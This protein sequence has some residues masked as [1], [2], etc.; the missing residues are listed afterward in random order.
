[1]RDK[2]TSFPTP[3][4]RKMLLTALV[5]IGCL[6]V[7]VAFTIFAKDTMML[8]LSIAVCAFCFFRAFTMFR[9]ASK[10]ITRSSRE[11]ARR[12]CLSS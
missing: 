6:L 8:F 3:L 7:G 12:L 10:R 4:K 1:M 5:G 11:H 2:W 9:V